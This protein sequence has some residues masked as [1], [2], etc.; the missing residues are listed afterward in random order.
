MVVTSELGE[1]TFRQDHADGN[2]ALVQSGY[3]HWPKSLGVFVRGQLWA[4]AMRG[5]ARVPFSRVI[6][7]WRIG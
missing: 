1:P 3:E 7:T 2:I 6:K 5:L 4:P